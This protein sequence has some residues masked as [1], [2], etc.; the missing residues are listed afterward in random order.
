MHPR[1]KAFTLVELLVVIGI[2]ALLVGILIPTLS[3]ARASAQATVCLSNLRELGNSFNLY[4]EQSGGR[5]PRVNPLPFSNPLYNTQPIAYANPPYNEFP[6]LLETFEKQIDQDSG[7]W[8]CPSDTLLDISAEDTRDAAV[9][10]YVNNNGITRYGDAYGTS[11]DYNP[12]VNA[13]REGDKFLD[14]LAD[15]KQR[16]EA[17]GD[18]GRARGRQLWLF[19]DHAAFHTRGSEDGRQYLFS[20]WSAGPREDIASQLRRDEK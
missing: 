20:D 12:F 19:R 2:I 3:R 6:S 4:L 9:V 18:D 8:Q 1:P 7:A 14:V 10:D 15:H 17:R 13:F 5:V 11:Y 16:E